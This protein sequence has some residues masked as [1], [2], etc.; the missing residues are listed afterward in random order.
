MN[1]LPLPEEIREA[2]DWKLQY[3][4][5]RGLTK[6]EVAVRIQRMSSTE[7]RQARHDHAIAVQNG[8]NR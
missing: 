4:S 8:R 5:K 6:P 1:P 3:V 7:I 2:C